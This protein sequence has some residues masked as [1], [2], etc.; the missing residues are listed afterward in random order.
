MKGSDNLILTKEDLF[1]MVKEKIGED[2]SDESIA[3]IENLT[4]TYNDLQEKANGDGIDWK[5][6]YEENDA[7]WK[8][9]YKERFFNSPPSNVEPKDEEEVPQK[10]LTF[11]NLFN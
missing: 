5:A 3:F 2:N 4:D 11:E 8:T 6:K 9:R 10:K 1:N 7:S